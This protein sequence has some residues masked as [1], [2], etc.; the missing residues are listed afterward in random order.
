MREIV[1]DLVEAFA[2]PFFRVCIGT[3]RN[4]HCRVEAE[5]YGMAQSP[6]TH[7]SGFVTPAYRAFERFV[8]IA[9]AHMIGDFEGAFR[10]FLVVFVYALEDCAVV[11]G[12]V[13]FFDVGKI[14]ADDGGDEFG[15]FIHEFLHPFVVLLCGPAAQA[16]DVA[17]GCV[18]LRCA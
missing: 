10:T 11:F 18:V 14:N 2:D 12:R 16:D 15:I 4:R 1:G 5:R 8:K 7:F 9:F 17:R 3:A 13:A 6:G